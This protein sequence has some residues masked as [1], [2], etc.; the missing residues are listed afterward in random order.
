M[1]GV[2]RNLDR[3]LW[4][5]TKEDDVEVKNFFVEG[6][7]ESILLNI[8]MKKKRSGIVH[9]AGFIVDWLAQSQIRV[10]LKK[11]FSQ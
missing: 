11:L 4:N 10:W 1:A 9:K 2:Q 5:K 8:E 7:D 3:F 6:F